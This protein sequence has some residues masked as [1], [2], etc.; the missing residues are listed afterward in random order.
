M[1]PKLAVQ[2]GFRPVELSLLLK[3]RQTLFWFLLSLS[4][5][6]YFGVITWLYLLNQDYSVQDDARQHVVFLQR[7]VDGQLFP[8]DRI[9]DYFETMAPFGYKSL[10]WVGAKLGIAPV[11]FAKVLPI[12]LSFV[13]TIYL[14]FICLHLFPIP[15][16]GFLSSLIL[17][18][19]LWMNDDLVSATPR[20]FIYPICAA[21]LYYLLERSLFPLLI[22]IALQGLFFPQLVFVQVLI[23]LL[24]IFRW[25]RLQR[26]THQEDY[27]FGFA[28]TLVAGLV[29]LPYALHVSEFGTALTAAQMQSMPEYGLVGRNQ[30]FGVGWWQFWFWGNSGIRIPW[31]PS[32]ILV[33]LGL[34]LLGRSRSPLVDILTKETRLLGQV[35]IASFSMYGLAHLFLLKLHFPSRYTYHTLRIILAIAAGIVLTVLLDA[36]WRWLRYRRRIHPRLNLGEKALLG[37][38]ASLIGIMVLVPAIPQLFLPFQGWV[39][40]EA[41]AIYEYLDTQPQDTLVASLAP[42]ANNLPAFTQRST[43]V[44][45][46]FALPHHPN[47]YDQFTQRAVDLIRAQYSSEIADVIKLI[48]RYDIDFFLLERH[49]LNPD[50]LLNQDWLIHSSFQ[51]TVLETIDQLKQGNRPALSYLIDQCSAASTERLVL[52]EAVCIKQTQSL[53]Q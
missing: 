28:G 43:L 22:T 46:E 29:L 14:F 5:P 10:Y 15:I 51:E 12:L 23:L 34:P 24:R 16:S 32:V 25:R 49:S 26:S 19:H 1:H 48:D 9:A 50:Y 11:G 37:L 33:G 4:V 6:L 53:L 40:G 2:Q 47:Y 41:P 30:Y 3:D 21:F 38:T 31:F 13:T 36:G 39:V 8:H 18:Q 44:G 20:A 7:F 45:R 52:V 42:D 35:V 17:N 27:I